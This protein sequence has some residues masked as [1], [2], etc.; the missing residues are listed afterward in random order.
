[1]FVTVSLEPVP[2][3]QGLEVLENPPSVEDE[4]PASRRTS[5]R[6]GRGGSWE[7]VNHLGPP[8]ILAFKYNIFC[9]TGTLLCSGVSP[10]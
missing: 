4:P 8:L 3:R 5:Q 6:L 9:L 2:W 1:M 7:S 10:E